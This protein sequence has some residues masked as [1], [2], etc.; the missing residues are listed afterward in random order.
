MKEIIRQLAAYN[1]WANEKITE[2][3]LLV[4]DDKMQETITSSFSSIQKTILHILDAE[5][6]WWQRFRLQEKIIRPSEVFNGH[7]RELAAELIAQSKRW[8]AWVHQATDN[9]LEHVFQYHTFSGEQFKQPT[10]QM[11]VHVFNHGTYHRGQLVTMFRQAGI[12]K[13]PA[14]DFVL[15]TRGQK[16]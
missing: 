16:K 14:T 11:L 10:W 2:T 7:A 13:L 1:V 9:Q 15:W 8:E 5:S 3:A 12:T 6:I 4:P